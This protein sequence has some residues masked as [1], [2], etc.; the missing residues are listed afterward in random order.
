MAG[1]DRLVSA[2]PRL[3]EA[4]EAIERPRSGNLDEAALTLSAVPLDSEGNLR[5]AKDST[6]APAVLITMHGAGMVRAPLRLRHLSVL[7]DTP[8]RITTPSGA[9]ESGRFTVLRCIDGTPELDRYFL[10]VSVAALQTR[11]PRLSQSEINEVVN[12]LAELFRMVS[13]GT[14]NSVRGLWAELLVIAKSTDPER[15]IR[16]WHLSNNDLHDFNDGGS[17]LEVKAGAQSRRH[18]FSAQQLAY[19]GT[20]LYVVSVV[21]EQTTHGIGIGHLRDDICAR[22]SWQADLVEKVDRGIADALG[23]RTTSVQDLVFDEVRGVDSMRFY[24]HDL[25]PRLEPPF[26]PAISHVEFDVDFSHVQDLDVKE[27]P[28]DQLLLAAVPRSG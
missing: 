22:V 11:G 24:S 23:D 19:D 12:H 13:A 7:F 26:H 4:F 21:A 16:A 18:R 3:L 28:R 9:A 17:R 20:P 1:S 6:G 14:S 25:I 27:L 2:G 5:I 15:L 8:C 10:V